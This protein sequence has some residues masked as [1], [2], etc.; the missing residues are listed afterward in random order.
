MLYMRGQGVQ[1]DKVAGLALLLQS[2]TIDN[3]PENR[4]RQNVSSIRG[5]TTKMIAEAQPLLAELGSTESILVPLDQ[6]LE[7]H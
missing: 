3:S 1:Q 6:Y 5:L 4:A 2:A 7:S